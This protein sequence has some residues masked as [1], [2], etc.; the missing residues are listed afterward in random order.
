MNELTRIIN[1]Q[2]TVIREEGKRRFK[3]KEKMAEKIAEI[4][5]DGIGAD[6]VTVISTQEFLWEDK[7]THKAAVF[8]NADKIR[9]MSVEDLA[10]VI[11]C[12]YANHK[13]GEAPCEKVIP[14]VAPNEKF[15]SKCCKAWLNRKAEVL[16][17]KSNQ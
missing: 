9:N 8:T 16:D 3:T 14:M 1:L 5:K 13:E 4:V 10:A 6:D 17:G 11:M 7:K 12:P 2:V 15:C